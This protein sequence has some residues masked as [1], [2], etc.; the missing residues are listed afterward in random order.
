MI[1]AE[2]PD[3]GRLRQLYLSGAIDLDEFERRLGNAIVRDAARACSAVRAGAPL[4]AEERRQVA[5]RIAAPRPRRRSVERCAVCRSE[6]RR[7]CEGSAETA[8]C[9]GCQRYVGFGM[10]VTNGHG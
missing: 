2:L 10:A 3:E 8:W 7:V 6:V 5:E 9:P 1:L 4:T